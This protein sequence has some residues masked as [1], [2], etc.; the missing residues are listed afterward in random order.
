MSLPSSWRQRRFPRQRGPRFLAWGCV[1]K[2]SGQ[3][4]TKAL[5]RVEA[6]HLVT[7]PGAK[8]PFDEFI[9]D[10][11]VEVCVLLEQR[12]LKKHRRV[13]RAVE[14]ICEAEAMQA[15]AWRLTVP[16]AS[17][18]SIDPERFAAVVS[19]ELPPEHG[20]T[21]PPAVPPWHPDNLP[22]GES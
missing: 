12:K 7:R 19:G 4:F 2:G 22:R 21:G 10:L 20:G 3:L 1:G 11:A 15:G 6:R 13:R 5:A 8:V 9:N 18:A 14:A 17:L 16:G